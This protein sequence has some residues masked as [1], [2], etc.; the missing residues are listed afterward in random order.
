MHL[1]NIEKEKGETV[2]RKK[3]GTLHRGHLQRGGKDI[4]SKI[5]TVGNEEEERRGSK[6]TE[7]RKTKVCT[8]GNGK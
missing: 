5:E 4:R 3:R 7:K 1:R 6:K 8:E 2:K